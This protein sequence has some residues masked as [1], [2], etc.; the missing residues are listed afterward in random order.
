MLPDY[1]EI[2]KNVD[3]IR[4]EMARVMSLA[5]EEMP[6]SDRRDRVMTLTGE[7]TQLEVKARELRDHEIEQLRQAAIGGTPVGG[8]DAGAEQVTAFRNFLRNGQPQAALETG[9]DSKGGY[10]MPTPLRAN[11]IDI[12]RNVS[13]IMA[14][15][16]IFNLTQPGTFKVELPRKTG[17]S[18]GGWVGEKSPRP[19]TAAPTIGMQ[20]LE[21]FGWYA[22]PEA[23]QKALDAIAESE[24]LVLDDI[25][26]TWA[27]TVNAAFCVG[28][29]VE[30]PAGAFAATDFYTV[31]LSSTA[32]SNDA[33]QII[34]AYFQ[35]AAKYLLGGKWFMKGAT[36][37]SLL[38]VAWP[39][40]TDTPLVKFNETTG[41]ATILGKPVVTL[42]DAP[43]AGNG[44]FPIAFGDMK[45]GYAVGTHSQITT[46]RDPL[47]NKPYV[48]FY[49]QGYSGGCPWDPQALLLLKSDNA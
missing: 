45:R 34:G 10:I 28:D 7:V 20:Q 22:Y 33:A 16:T 31:R 42:D 13:P 30:K 49:T 4:A 43:S 5:D 46:L 17:K 19:T 21:C 44:A 14:E 35:L 2:E 48:G 11:L 37:A 26:D 1:R 40:L 6:A 24:Q 3:D 15:A 25:A 32:D 23:T 9:D 36:L 8:P 18:T 12:V 39:N 27:E 29:G 41:E 47:T 38:G